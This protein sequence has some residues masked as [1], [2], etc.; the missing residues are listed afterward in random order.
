MAG[1]MPSV[2]A[3]SR[4]SRFTPVSPPSS[5]TTAL[6]SSATASTGGSTPLSA[7]QGA[8]Q[9]ITMPAAHSATTGLPRA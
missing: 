6:P 3:I 4:A 2:S 5:G 1:A 8:T 7:R 9:R